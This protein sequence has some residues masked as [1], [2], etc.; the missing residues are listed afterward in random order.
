MERKKCSC[1]T[2][3]GACGYK[4]GWLKFG[5]EKIISEKMNISVKQLFDKYLLVDWWADNKGKD[6][7]GLS[8]SVTRL[9]PGKMFDYNPTG[10]CIFYK[11][12]LCDIHSVSPFECQKYI[13]THTQS[14]SLI[15]HEECAKTWDI[16]EA[17]KLIIE[18]LGYEPKPIPPTKYSFF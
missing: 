3:K 1:D 18:L 13:H 15:T 9:T 14:D 2:C 16:P 10:K 7:F 8:P 5:D 6:Y 11:D 17:K 12:G 4:P